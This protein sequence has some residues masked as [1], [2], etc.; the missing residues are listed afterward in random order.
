V[1]EYYNSV[2]EIIR[3]GHAVS[4]LGIHKLE[5]DIYIGFS[6]RPFICSACCF[7][8]SYKKTL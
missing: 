8:D 6:P 7:S 1:T 5:A 2:L 4:F 3:P